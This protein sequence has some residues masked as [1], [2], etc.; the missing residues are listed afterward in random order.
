MSERWRFLPNISPEVTLEQHFALIVEEHRQSLLAPLSTRK[1]LLVA[2]LLDHFADRVFA[3][4]RT[5]MPDFLFGAEDLPAYRAQLAK[6]SAALATIFAL[7]GGRGEAALRIDAIIVPTVDYG[8][9]PV[10]DFMVSLYNG[11]SVQ[12]V[13]IATRDGATVLAH[14][15]LT[16]ALADWAG[17]GWHE[18]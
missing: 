13:V 4:F 14:E 8:A 6:R 15:V 17:M 9:L 10:E 3:R 7:C 5:S 16:R 2:V 12:R 18:P 1:V 11:N